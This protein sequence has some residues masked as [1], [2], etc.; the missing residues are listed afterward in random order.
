MIS[1]IC[2]PYRLSNRGVEEITLRA[3]VPEDAL[4]VMM[5]NIFENAKQNYL[6]RITALGTNEGSL[7]SRALNSTL[8]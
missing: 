2:P 7:V 4:T 1:T 3:V 6:S 8:Y 5:M